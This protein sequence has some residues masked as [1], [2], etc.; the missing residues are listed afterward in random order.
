MAGRTSN[1]KWT[2]G[3]GRK[4]GVQDAVRKMQVAAPDVA[5]ISSPE[6]ALASDESSRVFRAPRNPAVAQSRGEHIEWAIR[7]HRPEL[8]RFDWSIALSGVAHTS[9][10]LPKPSPYYPPS[11]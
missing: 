10:A 6:S 9:H 11:L 8:S 1:G 5:V 7:A 2:R 3:K 4:M